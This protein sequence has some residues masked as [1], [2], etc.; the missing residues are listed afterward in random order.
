[1]LGNILLRFDPESN[2]ITKAVGGNCKRHSAL[3]KFVVGTFFRIG[4]NSWEVRKSK[5]GEDEMKKIMS[6]LPRGA[7][8]KKRQ[9]EEKSDAVDETYF[10]K[11]KKKARTLCSSE[12]CAKQV[13]NSGVCLQH[14]AKKQT[15]TRKRCSSEGCAKQAQNG[16]VCF[17]HG[18]KRKRT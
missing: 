15:K 1:M 16:G 8:P 13:V 14:G 4:T 2:S 5:V 6:A 10:K 9:I 11:L 18:T 12:G 3:T 17:A 7:F